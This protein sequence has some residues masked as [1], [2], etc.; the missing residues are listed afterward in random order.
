[1]KIFR[2]WFL[3]FLLAATLVVCKQVD[4][5]APTGAEIHLT[6][7]PLS[8]NLGATSTLTVTGTRE[9]GAPLPDG[10]VIRFTVSDNLGAVTPNPVE[11]RNGIATATFIAGQRSGS[12]IITAFSGEITSDPTAEILIGEARIARLI[13]TANPSSLPPEGGKVQLRAF[14]RDENGNP[15]SGVQVFFSTDAGSLAS[16]GDPVITNSQGLARDTLTTDEEATVTVVAGGEEDT[17][18]I[19]L[20]ATNA[21]ECGSFVAPNPAAIG[22]EITFVDTS[23]DPENDLQT[24]TWDFGDGNSA[25][26]FVVTHSYDESGIFVVLHTITDS[27]GQSDNCEPIVVTI[28]EGQAPACSF[29]FAPTDPDIGQTVSFV[30]TSDDPDGTIEDS[31]WDFGDGNTGSGTS[32]SHIYT[33]PASFI[34]QHT[35]TDDQGLSSSCTAT[36][37]VAF[38]GTA[39]TCNFTFSQTSALTIT[40]N[41]SSSADT[42]E[43]GQSITTYEWAFGD[44]QTATLGSPGISHTYSSANTYV[45][46]LAVTDDEGDETACTP[47]SVPVNP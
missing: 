47:Q 22:Q 32:V 9:G 44:G 20:G 29:D 18:T 3:P 45:V 8:V 21:P 37:N 10:T 28:E 5:T 17:L 25:N 1:M 46:N 16:G 35:V 33:S 14:V 36:V 13:L 38:V 40:F 12:A 26:G 34:V 6:A 2:F 11:T 42:D 7:Q 19:S 43:N 27:E 39:P 23:T 31:D 15:V 4:L 41:A 24:S 30:D